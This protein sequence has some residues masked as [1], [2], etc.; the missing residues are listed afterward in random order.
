VVVFV[1]EVAAVGWIARWV[2]SDAEA[3]EALFQPV[4]ECAV[5]AHGFGGTPLE[6]VAATGGK[7]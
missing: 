1:A 4:A 5:V 7:G 3:V 2:S 6:A